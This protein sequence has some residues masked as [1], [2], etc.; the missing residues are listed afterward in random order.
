VSF[1]FSSRGRHTISTR[2]WSSDVCS[3]DL[4][5]LMQ[6]A[7]LR[8]HPDPPDRRA[9]ARDGLEARLGSPL[10]ADAEL[11]AR[12]QPVADV[13]LPPLLKIGRASCR[14]R[15]AAAWRAGSLAIAEDD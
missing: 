15:A 6:R 9:A 3:S 5:E 8:L 1:F 14:E 10:G 11:Q 13:H 4:A 12:T 2:D 7:P